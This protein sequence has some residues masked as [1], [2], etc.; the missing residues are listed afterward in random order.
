MTVESRFIDDGTDVGQGASALAWNGDAEERHRSPVRGGQAK[1]CP[2]QRGL[3]SSVRSEATERTSR[4]DAKIDVVDGD[5]R[6]ESLGEAV[7]LDSP[8][9]GRASTGITE[10]GERT[11]VTS[12]N[13]GHVSPSIG[14]VADPESRC[15]RAC[16]SAAVRSNRFSRKDESASSHG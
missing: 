6:A 12:G 14:P 9:A 15:W 5:L 10:A 1:Q 7:H 16:L 3:A 8:P 13:D 4:R 2:N 11:L